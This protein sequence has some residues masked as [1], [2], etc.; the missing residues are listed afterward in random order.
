MTTLFPGQQDSFANPSS[1][2]GLA[3]FGH[4]ALHSNVNDAI[5]A[6]EAKIGTP[7]VSDPTCL[8]ERVAATESIANAALPA[9]QAAAG[10][11]IAGATDKATPVDADSVGLSDSEAAGVLKKWSWA[12]IKTSITTAL[13]GV[14]ARL[15]G[16]AGGQTLIG[17]T[18]AADVLT[19]QGTS[20]TGTGTAV[21]V[22]CGTAGATEAVTVLESGYVGI[23]VDTPASPLHVMSDSSQVRL[24]Y[25]AATYANLA[26]SG[27]GAMSIAPTGLTVDLACGG[28][29]DILGSNLLSNSTF[30]TDLASWTDSGS[31]WSW[32][33]GAAKHT[34]G[35]VSTLS[36][37][38]TVV[39]GTNYQV[40]FTI[41]GRTA[42]SITIS[43]GSNVLVN[44]GTTTT[45]TASAKRSVVSTASGAV[46]F[47]I[48]PTSDFNGSVDSLIVKPFAG[49]L[50]GQVIVHGSSDDS[51]LW[52]STSGASTNLGIGL[53]SHENRI[54]G[55][56]NVS[57][58]Y[59]TQTKLA[60][61]TYNNAFGAG[62]QKDLTDGSGNSAFGAFAQY[63]LTNGANNLSFGTSAQQKLKDGSNNC[64][65]GYFA[66]YSGVSTL[67][68]VA[69][70]YTS[71]YSNTDGSNNTCIGAYAGR[72]IAN[73]STAATSFSNGIYVGYKAHVS[74][75]SATNEICIGYDTAGLGSNTT[76]IGNANTTKTKIYGYPIFSP[77]A[78]AVPTVNGELTFE[79]TSNT[80]LTVKLKGSDGVIRSASLTLS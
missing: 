16:V 53:S 11:L 71:A 14:F 52:I 44:T 23:G 56:S 5:E 54:S 75:N 38:I 28:L 3:A 41:S 9:T 66:Q 60:N 76:A 70:G 46:N 35:A 74:A 8:I 79:A 39:S 36:Q 27:S 47:I 17:G 67:N 29:V 73:G 34:A 51:Q 64:A 21:K 32:V 61:G 26:V 19:L 15:A 25:D 18:Q 7:D 4:A 59:R 31:S 6:I 55:H 37:A 62:A 22:L 12:D 68:N 50:S 48:T 72:Y 2:N 49:S 13:T 24:G 69:F 57:L 43:V 45:F 33:S 77:G 42:G 10:A 40:E 80:S 78:S 58:G 30:D 63:E 65:F 1:S 20:A